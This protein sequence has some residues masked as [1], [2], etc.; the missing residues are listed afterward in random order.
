MREV[1]ARAGID[2]E[3][4]GFVEAHGT[5]TKVGDPIEAT[6][7]HKVFGRGRSHKDP[8]Y[9]GSVKSNI[10]HLE[11]ASG[12]LSVIKAALML[13]KGFILPNTNFENPNASIPFAEWNLKVC[14]S[15]PPS[16][17]LDPCANPAR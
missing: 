10:G 7:I 16:R 5:G 3:D 1:Y 4:A 11:N 15:R 2:P 9:I 12:I 8:L 14:R 17:H 6:A 13:E